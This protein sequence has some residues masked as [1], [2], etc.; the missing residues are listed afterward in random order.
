MPSFLSVATLDL[1]M[2]AL[3]SVEQPYVSRFVY[4][5]VKRGIRVPSYPPVST[6][7][8]AMQALASVEQPYASRFVHGG[9]V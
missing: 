5:G 3:V 8:P 4:G 9:V 2:Q 1:A 6:L 7:D